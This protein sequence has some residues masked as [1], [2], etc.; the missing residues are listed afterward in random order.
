M[1][2]TR[3]PLL[4]HG[5]LLVA[6][7]LL[8]GGCSPYRRGLGGIKAQTDGAL[9]P[10][11]KADFTTADPCDVAA[12]AGRGA[13]ILAYAAKG[14]DAV[15]AAVR[16]HG[17]P[18][19]VAI[20]GG[21]GLAVE[22]AY[23]DPPVLRTVALV[24]FW[25]TESWE[26][27]LTEAELTEVD[28]E[29]ILQAQADR[30]RDAVAMRGRVEM[31]GR[32][33]LRTLD[34]PKASLSIYGML[35][36]EATPAAARLYGGAAVEHQQV[37]AW[38]DPRG[39]QREQLRTGDRIITAETNLAAPGTARMPWSGPV[40]LTIERD[41]ARRDLV[42]EPERLP[43]GIRFAVVDDDHPN[44]MAARRA[45]A[46]AVF[47]TTG[48]LR[49]ATSDDVLA[50]A[51]GHELAH[52]ALGHTRADRT[53]IDAFNDLVRAVMLPLDVVQPRTSQLVTLP[54]EAIQDR[55][56][57]DQE[58]DADRFGVR[59]MHA[60]GYDPAGALALLDLLEPFSTTRGLTPYLARHP[61][62]P[63]RR[64]L[65][66]EESRRLAPVAA[67][68]KSAAQ[69]PRDGAGGAGDQHRH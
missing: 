21:S 37:V 33:M 65:V 69:P 62:F 48:L 44:A 51:L 61:P 34:E 68:E 18:D 42:V 56:D 54:L 23:L 35:L 59:Y 24:G 29:L 3:P 26:R 22:L 31:I 14:H 63:E 57:R 7:A 13:R 6:A 9:V 39:P 19:A 28:P 4:R 38:V 66:E 45:D 11:R 32:S 60:A 30:L 16:A 20:T 15:A 8:V 52:V 12:D 10:V 49:R 2:V 58:R 55:F 53:P 50:A 67:A 25:R 64:A 1:A 46:V 40:R 17:L 41:G 27:P 5:A 43:L 47:V 36:V